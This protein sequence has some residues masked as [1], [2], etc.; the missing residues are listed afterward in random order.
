LSRADI[1]RVLWDFCG[2]RTSGGW[3]LVAWLGAICLGALSILFTVL[4]SDRTFIGFDAESR[5]FSSQLEFFVVMLVGTISNAVILTLTEELGWRGY[6]YHLWKEFGFWKMSS[7]TGLVW[8]I[9]HAPVILVF[10]LNYPDNRILGVFIFTVSCILISPL[11]AKIRQKGNS[12]FAAG[13]LHGLA[14]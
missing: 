4:L 6:L 3:W 12:V 10:G 8:G 13:I 2:N 9:W 11:F 14:W 5:H 1:A 7:L